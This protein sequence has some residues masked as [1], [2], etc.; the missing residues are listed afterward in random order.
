MLSKKSVN[1]DCA[2]SLVSPLTVIIAI[3]KLDGVKMIAGIPFAKLIT[4]VSCWR[5]KGGSKTGKAVRERFDR[6][7]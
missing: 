5:V 2:C 4:K 7:L 1:A 6:L 3:L